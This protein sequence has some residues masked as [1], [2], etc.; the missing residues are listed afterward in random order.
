M[1]AIP[2]T[3]TEPDALTC[4]TPAARERLGEEAF[5]CRA[6]VR[7]AGNGFVV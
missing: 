6:A 4:T 7:I 5:V 3:E 1:T 2:S